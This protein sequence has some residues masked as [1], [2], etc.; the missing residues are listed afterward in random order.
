MPPT[1]GVRNRRIM[2]TSGKEEQTLAR[3]HLY[4]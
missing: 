3:L 1:K 2:V 4:S